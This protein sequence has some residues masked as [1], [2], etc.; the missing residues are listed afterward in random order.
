MLVKLTERGTITMPKGLRGQ[1]REGALLDVVMQDDGVLELRPQLTVDATQAWFWSERWQGM[2]READEDY[3]RGRFATFDD[4]E[5]FLAE[6]DVQAEASQGAASSAPT[7][8]PA[9]D[10]RERHRPVGAGL[11][12]PLRGVNGSCSRPLFV[13]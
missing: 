1:L 13:P 9:R 4:V 7:R 6:L 10:T 5:S 2:E 8:L 12:L 3:R 11:A